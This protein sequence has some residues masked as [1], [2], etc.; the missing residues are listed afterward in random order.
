M[1]HNP[2]HLPMPRALA[3][4]VFQHEF[5]HGRYAAHYE[6]HHTMWRRLSDHV[7]D[8][9]LARSFSERQQAMTIDAILAG[10]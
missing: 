4:D 6:A 3:F 2:R 9:E 5:Q 1:T 10:G 7:Y 8:R